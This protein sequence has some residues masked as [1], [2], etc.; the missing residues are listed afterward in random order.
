M[1][2]PPAPMNG[3]SKAR[4]DFWD[5]VLDEDRRVGHRVARLVVGFTLYSAA[6][7]ASRFLTPSWFNVGTS[8]TPYEVAGGVL[9]ALLVLRTNAGYDRWWE[10]RKLWGG[11]TNQCRNLA[12]V[13][14]ANGP[15]DP[16]WR[17]E[18][19]AWTAAFAHACRGASGARRPAVGKEIA[20]LIG[21][22]GPPGSPRPTTCRRRRG[23]L[24]AGRRSATPATATSSTR[25][26]T[27]RPRTSGRAPDRPPRRLRADPQDAAGLGLR[28]PD[29]PVHP[30]VLPD[31]PFALIP[32]VGWLTPIF[33][34]MIAYP[35]LALD[36]IAD[37]LQHPFSTRS[38][39]HLPL[40]EITANIER[41]V[42]ALLGPVA[43]SSRP[44]PHPRRSRRT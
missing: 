19:V 31:L 7:Y 2:G 14:L 10:A 13:A 3:S 35:L 29:P 28:R 30:P 39:N 36:Q 42:L 23:R 17:R 12:I 15:D 33:T 1:I 18:V 37:D 4:P 26:P 24:E 21:T 20:A 32:R 34:L 38:I 11:I 44:R 9:S 22:E 6:L 25:W 41:N 5:H 16:D 27:S 43:G 40:D 8:T